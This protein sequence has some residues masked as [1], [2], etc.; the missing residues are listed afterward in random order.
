MAK[1]VN[2]E[3]KKL[4]SEELKEL[5]SQLSTLTKTVKGLRESGFNI[6]LISYAIIRSAQKQFKNVRLRP[7][8]V[9]LVLKGIEN[10]EE[11]LTD[12]SGWE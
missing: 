3:L 8:D 2:P 1:K 11:Y 10:V 12:Q 4:F 9:K 7:Y 6:D 5:R